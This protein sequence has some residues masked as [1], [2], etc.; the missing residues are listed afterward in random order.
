MLNELLANKQ[1]LA[2]QKA[3]QIHFTNA[4]NILY[5]Y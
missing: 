2:E 3:L 1:E 5:C 4:M